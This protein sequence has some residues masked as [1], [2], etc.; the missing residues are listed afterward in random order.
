MPAQ[1]EIIGGELLPGAPD[2]WLW[3]TVQRGTKRMRR[4][5]KVRAA[6]Y[7]EPPHPLG[8]KAPPWRGFYYEETA[9]GELEITPSLHLSDDNGRAVLETAYRW[10]CPVL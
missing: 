5:I 4:R 9:D 10:R 1:A 7:T 6:D 2:G 3:I 8:L